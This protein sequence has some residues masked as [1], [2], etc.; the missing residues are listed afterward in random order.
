M[1][2]TK[3]KITHVMFNNPTN[4]KKRTSLN[5]Y[6]CCNMQIYYSTIYTF[7]IDSKHHISYMRINIVYILY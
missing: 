2:I 3:G 7:C 5:K 6:M 1:Q 4:I